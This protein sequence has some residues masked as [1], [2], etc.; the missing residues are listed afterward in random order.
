MKFLLAGAARLGSK[1][2]QQFVVLYVLY[3][4]AVLN[5]IAAITA[6]AILRPMRIRIM[7]KG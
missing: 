7:A 4:A 6:L 5:I 2:A 3:V 1:E